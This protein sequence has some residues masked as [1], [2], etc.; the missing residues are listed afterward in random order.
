MSDKPVLHLEWSPALNAFWINRVQS[1][2]QDCKS[3]TLRARYSRWGRD[4]RQ[5]LTLGNLAVAVGTKLT[6]MPLIVRRVD[7][8]LN[9]IG[10]V[11]QSDRS[12]VEACLQSG[13]V[14]RLANRDVAHEAVVDFDSFFFE[15]RS[16]YE[17]TV[18]F[19]ERFV[20]LILGKPLGTGSRKDAERRVEEALR[21][22]GANT[23]WIHELRKKRNLLIHARATRLAFEATDGDP[24]RFDPV[25]LTKNVERIE[26]D[27]DRLSIEQCRTLWQGFVGSYEHIEA[28][29]KEEVATA[30]AC[31]LRVGTPTHHVSA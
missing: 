24:F 10:K 15:S 9:E 11:L 6:I 31:S 1:A 16:A 26:D 30:D 23:H 28:W 2:L 20:N 21:H 13:A 8:R 22:R 29:L 12:Q 4:P 18:L 3:P 27:P 25:L 17:L 7:A 19:L 5:G 14:Y